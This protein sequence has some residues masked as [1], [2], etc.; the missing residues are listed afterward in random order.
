MKRLEPRN[1]DLERWLAAEAAGRPEEAEAALAELFA[2][3]PRLVPPAGFAGRVMLAVA[4]APQA[5][6]RSPARLPRPLRWTLRGLLAAAVALVA[7]GVPSLPGLL[8]PAWEWL[9]LARLLDSATA[10]LVAASRWLAAA[11]SFWEG[12]ARLGGGV[13]ETVAAPP[14]AAV[15]LVS[16]AAAATALCFLADLI[17]HERSWSHVRAH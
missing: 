11:M 10:C 12:L 17:A 6:L 14:V 9:S 4:L 15:L 13:A 2:A 8:A 1:S 16:L 5:L 3:L 7:L